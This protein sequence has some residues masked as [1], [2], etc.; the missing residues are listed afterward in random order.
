M[1]KPTLEEFCAFI[2]GSAVRHG[3][4]EEFPLVEPQTVISDLGY[5]SL[6]F[7]ELVMDVEEL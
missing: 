4:A 7:V 5:D 2:K 6:D 1:A 3:K